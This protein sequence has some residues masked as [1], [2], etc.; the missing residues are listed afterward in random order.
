MIGTLQ[1]NATATQAT[2]VRTAM[3]QLGKTK[4]L[5][6]WEETR[7]FTSSGACEADTTRVWPDKYVKHGCQEDAFIQY[8]ESLLTGDFPVTSRIQTETAAFIHKQVSM[9]RHMTLLSSGL[10]EVRIVSALITTVCQNKTP[11]PKLAC[12]KGSS[13]A[14]EPWAE[15]TDRSN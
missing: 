4:F 10:Y 2:V 13:S 7:T 3:G 6:T 1:R 11:E 15:A 8:I 9:E 5:P 14:V 12:K